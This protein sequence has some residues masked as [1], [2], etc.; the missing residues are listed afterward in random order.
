[1][2]RSADATAVYLAPHDPAWAVMARDEIA[3][4]APAIGSNLIEIHHI[5]STSIPGIVAKPTVDL[6]PIVHSL[7]ELDAVRPSIEALGY[8]WRG[9]FG[10]EGRRY[11]PLERDG[12][13]IFHVH[14]YAQGNPQIATQLAFRDY[15]RA[16]RDEAFAYEAI[17]REAAAA[18]P[19]DSLAYNKHKSDWIRACQTR[20]QAWS[21]R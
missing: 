7:D 13:R 10:I 4:L 15:L 20:A 17:K 12:R 9:E 8:I 6:M 21:A 1:M 11:C 5:G 3:R 16:H 19:S 18:H 2:T 14:F